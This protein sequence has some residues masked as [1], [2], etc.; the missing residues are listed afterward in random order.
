[1]SKGRYIMAVSSEQIA[2]KLE[3]KGFKVDLKPLSVVGVKGR[4]TVTFSVSEIK[5]DVYIENNKG[6]HVKSGKTGNPIEFINEAISKTS[7]IIA[8]PVRLADHLKKISSFKNVANIETELFKIMVASSMEAIEFKKVRDYAE[9]LGWE[10]EDSSTDGKQRLTVYMHNDKTAFIELVDS[11][12]TYKQHPSDSGSGA[13]TTDNPL[14]T[15][16]SFNF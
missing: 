13:I 11:V 8:S 3:S 5:Y 9:K 4:S 12:W 2:E 16:D 1:M 6:D 7:S 15:I 10:C 14:G